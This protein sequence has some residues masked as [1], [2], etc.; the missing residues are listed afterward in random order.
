MVNYLFFPAADK[1]QDNIW[2]YTENKWGR[3]QA[4]KYILGLHL[5]L[6]ELAGRQQIWHALPSSLIVPP[7]LDIGVYFSR[8]EHHQI[9]FRELSNNRIGI[10]SILHARADIPVRLNDDLRRIVDQE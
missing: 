8:Y 10:M 6:K 4:E 3:E 5:H 1:A 9:F 7:D 2:Q